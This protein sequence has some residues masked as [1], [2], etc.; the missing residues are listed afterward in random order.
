MTRARWLL[1]AGLSA[2]IAVMVGC[3][4][5]RTLVRASM[6]PN[7]AFDQQAAPAPPD[8]ADDAVWSAL[9]GRADAGD[10][11]PAGEQALDPTTLPADVFYVHPTTFLG[12]TWNGPTDD[13]DL[14]ATTDRV[15]T[16]IQAPAFNACCAVYAPRYRQATG[17]AFLTGTPDAAAAIELAYG[18]VKR[19]FGEFLARRGVDRPFILAGHSQ[20][21]IL[22]ERLLTEVIAGSPLQD[23]LVFA[24]LPGGGL[25]VDGLREQAPGLPVCASPDQTGCVVAWNARGP[26]YVPNPLSLDRADLR[27]LVCVNPLSWRSDEELVPASANPGAVFLEHADSSVRPGFAD[28]Q[29]RSGTLIVRDLGATPR[30][31]MSTLL[32]RLIGPQNHHP[33]EYQ[34]YFVSL[35]QNAQLRVS[36]W[37][38]T[39]P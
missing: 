21:S 3:S 25:T 14:N 38:A 6:I 5:V 28:A 17:G 30:D 4:N 29:C 26:A 27:P 15:A 16:G 9:P 33:I 7:V 10:A 34:I 20:G 23:R 36:A 31:L 12:R 1:F 24:V 32:D 22:A 18:D 39:H 2:S 35:R 13:A 37:L 19:A 11:T 8:Y